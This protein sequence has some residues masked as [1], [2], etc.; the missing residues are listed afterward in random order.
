[1]PIR[2][3]RAVGAALAAAAFVPAAGMPAGA[4][5]ATTSP[6]ARPA[7]VTGRIITVNSDV[8]YSPSH[9]IVCRMD[10]RDVTCEI[11]KRTYRLPAQRGCDGVV[12]YS[13]RLGRRPGMF[14]QSD[15]MGGLPGRTL[16]Y[17][18]SIRNASFVCSSTTTG[19][20]CKNRGNG[21]GFL[22]SKATYRMF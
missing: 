5:P 19:M 20:T 9:N 1:M 13:I 4:A 12:G 16:P 11:F 6:A 15:T 17:G 18:S 8:F 7:T 21:H 2:V 22:L 3:L 10:R 14:C